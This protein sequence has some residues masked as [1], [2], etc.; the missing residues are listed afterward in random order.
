MLVS[1][2]E[3]PADYEIGMAPLLKKIIFFHIK[4]NIA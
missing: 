2:F 1:L 4:S 3:K